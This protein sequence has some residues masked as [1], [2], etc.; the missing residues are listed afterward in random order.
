MSSIFQR[1]LSQGHLMIQFP[2]FSLIWHEGRA[3]DILW[4]WASQ[5]CHLSTFTPFLLIILIIQTTKRRKSSE[6][7][8][9]WNTWSF[10]TSLLTGAWESLGFLGT[11]NKTRKSRPELGETFTSSLKESLKIRISM[12]VTEN[13][14]D[15]NLLNQVYCMDVKKVLDS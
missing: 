5:I 8:S 4:P 11:S 15:N 13:N 6:F 12:G 2:N 10:L 7:S 9:P 1:N 3:M 14:D